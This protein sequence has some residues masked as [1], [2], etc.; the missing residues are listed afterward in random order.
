MA[1]LNI[2]SHRLYG[3][4][5]FLICIVLDIPFIYSLPDTAFPSSYN[6]A[7]ICAPVSFTISI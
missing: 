6:P 4:L 5:L 3:A 7:A 1:G 2:M